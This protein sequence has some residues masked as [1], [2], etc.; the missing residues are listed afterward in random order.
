MESLK[1]LAVAFA[2]RTLSAAVLTL[3]LVSAGN[4]QLPFNSSQSSVQSP[5]DRAESEEASD[6]ARRAEA[7]LQTGTAL[8]RRGA[9][10]EAI[11]HLVAARGQVANEYAASFN[12]ALCYVGTRQ[13]GR[14]IEILSGLRN[15]GHA[16]AD[17]Q[18]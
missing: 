5:T 3:T 7:E 13:F 2:S 17:V 6:R 15:S 18:N 8:T 11:P 9:F 12:L 4:A 14:A 10:A 1:L 16:N